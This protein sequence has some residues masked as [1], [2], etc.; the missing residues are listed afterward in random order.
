MEMKRTQKS[1]IAK[2]K[3]GRLTL[4]DSEAHCKA[5]VIKSEWYWYKDKWNNTLSPETD[6]HM[7]SIDFG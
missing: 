7:W 3:V 5:T 4:P 2:E 6:P 1:K